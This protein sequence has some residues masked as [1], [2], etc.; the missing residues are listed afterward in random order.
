MG[1]HCRCTGCAT[2]THTHTHTHTLSYEP[3]RIWSP[4]GLKHTQLTVC[5]P[6]LTHIHTQSHTETRT[7]THI[8]TQSHTH[9]HT[10]VSLG[11]LSREVKNYIFIF[12][13]V[14]KIMGGLIRTQYNVRIYI[15]TYL[16]SRGL[17]RA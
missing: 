3:L 13:D 8:H 11:Y 4:L 6:V 7:H 10:Y 15:H 1:S 9:T 2:H 16:T 12:W 17:I 14:T 5:L